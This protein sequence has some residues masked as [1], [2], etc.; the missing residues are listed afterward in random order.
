MGAAREKTRAEA[1][2]SQEEANRRSKI[3]YDKRHKVTASGLVCGSKVW[4]TD[5]QVSRKTAVGKLLPKWSGPYAITKITSTTAHI[6]DASG[7][8]I[9]GVHF[10]LLKPHEG[11]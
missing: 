6:K 8:V 1:A 5:K 9:K 3:K 11:K 10:D 4:K 2:R 7:N